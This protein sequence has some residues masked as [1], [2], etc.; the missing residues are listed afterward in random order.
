M[1]F[2]RIVHGW[3]RLGPDGGPAG[4]WDQLGLFV[5]GLPSTVNEKIHLGRKE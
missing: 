4:M 2:A 1:S 5:H 3:W